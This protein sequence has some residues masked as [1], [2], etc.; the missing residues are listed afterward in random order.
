MRSGAHKLGALSVLTRRSPLS[1]QSDDK[2]NSETEP[3]AFRFNASL[4]QLNDGF[5]NGES[6]AETALGSIEALLNLRKGLEDLRQHM[7]RNSSSAIFHSQLHMSVVAD[8]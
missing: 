3:R 4:M 5:Y 7:L 8:S 1:R 6:D 2:F